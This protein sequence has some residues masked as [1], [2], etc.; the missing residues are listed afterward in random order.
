[1]RYRATA[2]N[3]D[4]WTFMFFF[5]GLD[6]GTEDEAQRELN[7]IVSEDD[8]HLKYGPWVVNGIVKREREGLYA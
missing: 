8:Q 5:F 3:K 4:G 2:R 6:G 1:M 7:R